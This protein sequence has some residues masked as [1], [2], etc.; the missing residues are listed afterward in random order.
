MFC[1]LVMLPLSA[2]IHH[3]GSVDT[4][5]VGCNTNITFFVSA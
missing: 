2:G 4:F 3:E 1:Q 5:N